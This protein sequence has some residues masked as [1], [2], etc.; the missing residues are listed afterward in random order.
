VGGSIK[1]SPNAAT[2]PGSVSGSHMSAPRRT[3]LAPAIN[4]DSVCSSDTSKLKDP[5]TSIRSDGVSA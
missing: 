2:L 3:T 4:G 5:N 1:V